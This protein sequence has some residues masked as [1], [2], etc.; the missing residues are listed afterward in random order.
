MKCRL[1]QELGLAV[2]SMKQYQKTA[3]AEAFAARSKG[4]IPNFHVVQTTR[5]QIQ[6]SLVKLNIEHKLSERRDL[7][8][9]K[10]KNLKG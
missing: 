5:L 6:E 8:I 9:R 4:G 10:M 1:D 7:E 3:R 2:S